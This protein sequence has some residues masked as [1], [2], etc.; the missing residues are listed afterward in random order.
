MRC[1]HC[2]LKAHVLNSI[3][4]KSLNP[5]PATCGLNWTKPPVQ[6]LRRHDSRACKHEE[7][8]DGFAVGQMGAGGGTLARKAHQ[9]SITD[10]KEMFQF[11]V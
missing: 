5:H 10:K 11:S 7:G 2:L 3:Q 4:I 8:A 9:T 6:G 1:E